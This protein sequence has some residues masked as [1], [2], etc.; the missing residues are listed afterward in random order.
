MPYSSPITF[1]TIPTTGKTSEQRRCEC[2]S[3]CREAEILAEVEV[4]Q[5]QGEGQQVVKGGG[6][7]LFNDGASNAQQIPG[8]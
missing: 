5:R 1:S 2:A 8:D 7:I 3:Y 6:A 4:V